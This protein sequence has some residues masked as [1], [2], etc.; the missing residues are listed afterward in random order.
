MGSR[1]GVSRVARLVAEMICSGG[2]P[3]LYCGYLV[4]Q[5]YL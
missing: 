3:R 5:L 4:E 1:S 2:E